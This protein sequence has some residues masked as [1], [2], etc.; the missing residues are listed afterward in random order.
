MGVLIY[1]LETV[2]IDSFQLPFRVFLVALKIT[3]VSQ[4][5]LLQPLALVMSN[6]PA[7]A[8]IVIMLLPEPWSSSKEE[9]VVEARQS[10]RP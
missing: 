9:E 8:A 7:A 2:C 10:I 1:Q 4:Q 5:L 6:Q 3:L